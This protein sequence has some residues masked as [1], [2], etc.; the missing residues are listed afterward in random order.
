MRIVDMQTWPRHE[1]YQFFKGFNHPHFNMCANVDLTHLRPYIKSH[2]ISFS[3]AITYLISRSANA[4][5]EFRYRMR[6]GVLVEHETVSPSVTILVENDLFSFCLLE[7]THD[8]QVFA[9]QATQLIALVKENPT[10]KDPPNR[11]D[12]LYMTAIPW[13]SFT[14]FTHPMRQHPADYIPRFAWGKITDNG[15]RSQM[16]LSV[17][18]HHELMDGIHMGRLYMI[19]EDLLAHPETTLG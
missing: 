15:G 1:H 14:S 4:I 5:P 11:D 9:N 6:D 8:F 16:P 3:V 19:L 12:L 18:G 10:L 17:Q 2:Q 13:V 7:Y